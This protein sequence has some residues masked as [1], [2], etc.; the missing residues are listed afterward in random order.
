MTIGDLAFVDDD[1]APHSPPSD[2][3]YEPRP[4]GGVSAAHLKVLLLDVLP[5]GLPGWVVSRLGRLHEVL[6]AHPLDFV[7]LVGVEARHSL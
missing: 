7:E 4:M 1:R 5:V 6:R 3:V 2:V